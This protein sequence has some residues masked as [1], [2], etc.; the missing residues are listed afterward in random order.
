MAFF[1]EMAG[2]ALRRTRIL[3]Q[4]P[5]PHR[6]FPA[7]SFRCSAAGKIARSHTSKTEPR[8]SDGW[9]EHTPG[10]RLRLRPM[11]GTEKATPGGMAL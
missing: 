2:A 6:R 10:K 3:P 4:N 1:R 8:G 7:T 9:A 11:G 5:L